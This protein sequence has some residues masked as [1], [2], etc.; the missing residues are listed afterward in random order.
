MLQDQTALTSSGS[1]MELASDEIDHV[2]GALAPL[3][4][5]AYVGIALSTGTLALGGGFIGGLYL[6]KAT[7]K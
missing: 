5:V 7:H 2:G 1:I 4:A 6:A 3:I